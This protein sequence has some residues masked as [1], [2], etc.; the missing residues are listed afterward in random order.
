MLQNY[1]I[2]LEYARKKVIFLPK[3]HKKSAPH[4]S[5]SKGTYEQRFIVLDLKLCQWTVLFGTPYCSNSCCK[6]LKSVLQISQICFAKF[7]K[8]AAKVFKI[9]DIC[10]FFCVFFANCRFFAW[11]FGGILFSNLKKFCL[12]S[13]RLFACVQVDCYLKLAE[14]RMFQ[15]VLINLHPRDHVNW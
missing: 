10:K 6:I 11:L 13:C 2:F 14:F 1:N 8:S 4:V 9:F 5:R 15:M 3:G 12:A 7:S